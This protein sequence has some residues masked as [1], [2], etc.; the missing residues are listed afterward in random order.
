MSTRQS[1]TSVGVIRMGQTTME[2][3][4]R[5]RFACIVQL[6][7]AAWPSL[8]F[9]CSSSTTS[10]GIAVLLFPILYAQNG[11]RKSAAPCSFR[12]A[13]K[14]KRIIRSGTPRCDCHCAGWSATTDQDDRPICA[15]TAPGAL[16]MRV[17]AIVKTR[18]RR[19]PVGVEGLSA[20]DAVMAFIQR[21]AVSF[22]VTDKRT[23]PRHPNFGGRVKLSLSPGQPAGSARP[24]RAGSLLWVLN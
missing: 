19:R 22:M 21:N 8:A 11:D 5:Q 9:E 7:T 1:P 10:P 13:K 16:A 20:T 18:P 17:A 3:G 14:S 2:F 24:R 15:A 4:R 12:G 6:G 23:P